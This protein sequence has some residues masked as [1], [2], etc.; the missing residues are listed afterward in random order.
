M[1]VPLEMMPDILRKSKL[2][3]EP[4]TSMRSTHAHPRCSSVHGGRAGLPTRVRELRGVMRRRAPGRG[5]GP[6]L[7]QGLVLERHQRVPG[8]AAVE[9]AP[10]GPRRYRS[11]KCS[12]GVSWLC[13]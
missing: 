13:W 11:W 5:P 9:K 3:A 1:D 6:A 8:V 7:A 10:L 4:H 12:Y 2:L